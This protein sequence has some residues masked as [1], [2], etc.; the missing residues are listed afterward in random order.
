MHVLLRSNEGQRDWKFSVALC[1]P[2]AFL[3]LVKSTLLPSP[4]CCPIHFY[5]L[6]GA[7]DKK[8][9]VPWSQLWPTA[10]HFKLKTTVTTVSLAVWISLRHRL[11]HLFTHKDDYLNAS[12]VICLHSSKI[13][14]ANRR[15]ITTQSFYLTLAELSENKL[16]FN[17][18]ALNETEKEILMS[19]LHLNQET[20][21]CL[22]ISLCVLLSLD[23][24]RARNKGGKCD[25]TDDLH[26]SILCKG[27]IKFHQNKLCN[28]CFDSLSNISTIW[29]EST[30]LLQFPAASQGMISSSTA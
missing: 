19:V 13:S 15:S 21:L 27:F 26:W 17:W 25:L 16:C 6:T 14:F 3:S 23:F 20:S 4:P 10:Q 28:I 12:V 24:F 18:L 9:E 2:S 5:S 7:D 8:I 29:F 11:A 22:L 1:S 30:Q